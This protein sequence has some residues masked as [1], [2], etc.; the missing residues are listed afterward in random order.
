MGLLDRFLRYAA[1]DTQSRDGVASTP[2]SPGQSV[3]AAML[4][5][6]LTAL[7]V[8]QAAVTANSYCIGYLPGRGAREN[9]P[10]IGLI[11]H[12]DTALE[13]SGE[14]IKPRV[15]PRYDGGPIPL[16]NSLT[17]DPA[18]FPALAG[19]KGKTLVVTDGTTLLGADDKAG[20][21]IIMTVLEELK[22][23]PDLPHPPL[24]VAFTPDEEIGHGAALL[25][26]GKFGADFAYTVDGGGVGVIEYENFNAA[27]ATVKI[28]GLAIHPG[29]A[30]DKM[31]NAVLLGQ[32]LLDEL[33]EDERPENTELR[34][35]FFH[36][37]SFSG[38]VATARIDMLV[39]DH[40]E[41]SFAAKK[42]F[43][44]AVTERLNKR[45]PV[46]EGQEPRFVLVLD[47]QYKNMLEKIRPCMYI[48][49][50]AKAAMLDLGLEPVDNP[51]RGGTDGARL[52]WRGLPC[53]NLF[54]G[55]YNVHGP[56][57]FA[58][59]EEMRLAVDVILGIVGKY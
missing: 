41:R 37:D 18:M 11:A 7:D 36:V 19:K 12:L 55:S 17:L 4:A 15:V 50:D 26:L 51:I 44:V 33:P 8:Q 3:L 57:E 58:V 1:V 16:G 20:V 27:Y 32:A 53:P 24:A 2:S 48:V 10:T 35:G 21:A 14:N 45:W 46:P 42:A 34:Q 54:D 39:R 38:D 5:E 49:N 29:D 22:N 6:E 47:D 40:D 31:V 23:R 13:A 56:Y 25:D 28:R 43:L 52:S 59:V 30:K 9:A